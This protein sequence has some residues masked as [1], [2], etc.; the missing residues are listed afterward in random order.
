METFLASTE[1]VDWH[2]P[3][4]RALADELS[5]QEEDP[6]EIAQRCFLWVRDEIRH[7]IDYQLSPVTCSAS[8]VLRERSGFCYAKSHLLAAL[9]RANGLPAA[10]CYQR[11]SVNDDGAPYCLHGLNAV[12]LPEHGWYRIDARGNRPGVDAR[13]EPPVERLAFPLDLPGERD[14]PG[15]YSDPLPEVVAALTAY[16]DAQVLLKHLPD[17]E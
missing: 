17:R 2:H 14:L 3:D 6:T 5:R 11:L 15:Y 8:Q 7:S 16:D 10:F 9:L 1:V 12:F 13:F 4:V